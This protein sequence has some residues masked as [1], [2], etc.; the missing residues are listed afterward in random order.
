MSGSRQ[1]GTERG[2]SAAD[3]ARLWQTL[4][5]ELITE[6]RFEINPRLKDDQTGYIEV[7]VVSD[8]LIPVDGAVSEYVWASKEFHNPLHLISCG[9]LFDLL[10]VAYRTIDRFFEVGDAAAPPRRKR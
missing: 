4:T 6:L 10:I 5:S 2:A 1:V 8:S 7:A 3:C 9:Q